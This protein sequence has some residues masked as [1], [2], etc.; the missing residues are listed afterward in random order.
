MHA[1]HLEHI[2]HFRREKIDGVP[3]IFPATVTALKSQSLQNLYAN[4]LMRDYRV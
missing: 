2:A 3:V 4:P 1:G